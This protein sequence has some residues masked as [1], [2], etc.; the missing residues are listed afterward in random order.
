MY[1]CMCIYKPFRDACVRGFFRAVDVT[2]RQHSTRL[3]D[4]SA[5][6]LVVMRPSVSTD[7]VT[8]TKSKRPS[9]GSRILD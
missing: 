1:V 8:F 7:G 2:G 4:Y 6:G 9:D 3:A 5:H